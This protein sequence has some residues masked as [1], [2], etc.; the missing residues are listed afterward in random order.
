M[1]KKIL[2]T[3]IC[4]CFLVNCNDKVATENGIPDNKDI[5]QTDTLH[6]KDAKEIKAIF[7]AET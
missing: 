6:Q 7:G 4:F 3:L 1:T 2:S 5:V